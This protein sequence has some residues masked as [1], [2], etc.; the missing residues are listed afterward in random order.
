MGLKLSK[1]GVIISLLSMVTLFGTL[2]LTGTLGVNQIDLVIVEVDYFEHWNA[3]ILE[4]S[5]KTLWSGFGRMD[6]GFR[7]SLENPWIISVSVQKMD[8]TNGLLTIKLRTKDGTILKEAYT[9]EP[10]GTAKITVEI[11]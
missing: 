5:A 9:V 11:S 1:I 10:F 6:K 4:D 7:R 2:V 3:T 8:G